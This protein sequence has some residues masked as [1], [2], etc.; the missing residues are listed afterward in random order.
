MNVFQEN[1]VISFLIIGLIELTTY[2]VS[3]FFLNT[4]NTEFKNIIPLHKKTYVT[5]NLVKSFFLGILS[6]L[7]FYHYLSNTLFEYN[8]LYNLGS[9]YILLDL[10]A[11]VVVH[12]MQLTTKIHHIIVQ[13]LFIICYFY[14]F[15]VSTYVV[16]GIIIYTV[17]S[18]FAFM[19]N[20]FLAFR[21]FITNR[22]LVSFAKISMNIYI[23]CCLFNWMHQVYILYHLQLIVGLIYFTLLTLI[24]YDDITL[25]KYLYNFSKSQ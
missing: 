6:I 21:I 1:N 14:E 2:G 19:V 11:L 20:A 7:F 4:F 17:F 16:Q 12:K 23:I 8:V 10:I 22:W 15:D 5:M 9:T 18:S 25:I 3:Y 13:I 24:I